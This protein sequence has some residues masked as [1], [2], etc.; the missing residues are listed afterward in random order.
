M[1]EIQNTENHDQMMEKMWDNR[2]PHSLPV[3]M[4]NDMPTLEHGRFLKK[5]IL[6][7]PDKLAIGLLRISPKRVEKLCS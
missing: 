4:E 2:N 1:V 3:G 5:L 7:L 6:F